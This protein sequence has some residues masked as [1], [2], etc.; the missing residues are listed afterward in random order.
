M[1]VKHYGFALLACALASA[2]IVLSCKY[3]VGAKPATID[4]DLEHFKYGSIGAEVDGYPLLVWRELPTLFAAELPK[5][6]ETFGF[7]QERGRPLPVGI[8]VRHYGVDRVGFNCATCHT[9]QLAGR[10]SVIAGA[11][12][13]QL[14]LQT[15]LRF[16][17]TTSKQPNF[18]ADAIFAAAQANQRPFGWLDK[19]VFRYYVIPT[20]KSKLADYE[21]GAGGWMK[22]R[23]DHGPGRTDAG[24]PWRHKFNLHPERDTITGAVE[25]PSLW[26]QRIRKDIW[27]HWD[28]NNGSLQERNISAAL[29]GGAS[30]ESLD[31]KSI[32]RV[33]AW[34]LDLPSPGFPST[35]S[36]SQAERGKAIYITHCSTCHDI[37]RDAFGKVT[38]LDVVKTDP[39]RVNLFS[40]QMVSA[41]SSVGAGKPW[42]FKHYRKTE[43]YANA[44][45]DGIWARAPYL[46][47]GSVPTLHDLLLPT[48]QRPQVFF[49]GCAT[50]DPI[51]IGHSCPAGFRFDTSL[52]GNSNAGHEWG[53]AL[54]T[55]QRAELLEYLK[56]L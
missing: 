55:T 53:T 41:F 36:I 12:A 5:G 17:I 13:D 31:H 33:A 16:L 52:R 54:D 39:D 47:N 35:V 3:F 14:D 10:Y 22:S 43:G 24:N 48:E 2:A 40:E 29:A 45:L 51:K 42:R 32:Q 37:G 23:P 56:T 27:M 6:W 50:F 34:S 15:Y 19:L 44:P 26:Q 46:H 9:T 11:P 25:I 7:I 49:K 8:S 21:N 30:E 20:I 38:S 1:T 4:D 18:N 28:G